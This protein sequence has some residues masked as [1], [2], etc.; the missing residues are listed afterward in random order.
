MN[1]LMTI[2]VIVLVAIV[3]VSYLAWSFADGGNGESDASPVRGT[4]DMGDMVSGSNEISGTADVDLGDEDVTFVL[5]GENFKF[6]RD[7]NDNPEL[8][9]KRGDVVRVEFTSAQG[10]H[11]WVVDEFGAT[12]RQVRPEDG[13]TY[14][15]F[16]ADKTGAFEY[17]CAVGQHRANGMWGMLIVSD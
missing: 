12:T 4:E 15:E 1:K 5:T 9:V 7:G 6:V 16:V 17:Y 10:F 2:G 3:A 11:D 13:M 14:V 8:R